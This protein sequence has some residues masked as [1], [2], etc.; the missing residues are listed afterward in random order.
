[1]TVPGLSFPTTT[2]ELTTATAA[3]AT[4]EAAENAESTAE[5]KNQKVKVGKTIFKCNFLLVFTG[6]I[7]NLEN[8]TMSC[9]GKGSKKIAKVS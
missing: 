8:S 6:V 1:V 4:T 7:L 3:A 2:R 5:I 9:K